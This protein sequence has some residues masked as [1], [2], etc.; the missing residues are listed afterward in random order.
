MRIPVSF[1]DHDRLFAI[2]IQLVRD[3]LHEQR[4]ED[5]CYPDLFAQVMG[6][7][8]YDE[9]LS[10]RVEDIHV[11]SQ[12][13]LT[14]TILRDEMVWNAFTNGVC[15]YLQAGKL[16]G[17]IHRER[18]DC[19]LLTSETR[20]ANAVLGTTT[21]RPG[22]TLFSNPF[23]YGS[24]GLVI[25]DEFPYYSNP[26][27]LT[28]TPELIE[29]GAPLYRSSISTTGLAFCW[30]L[31]EGTVRD[32]PDDLDERLSK[33]CHYAPLTDAKARRLRFWQEEIIPHNFEP[34][35]DYARRKFKLPEGVE[36]VRT[37]T[38]WYLHNKALGGYIPL[39]FTPDSNA[40]YQAV[41]ALLCGQT[42]EFSEEDLGPEDAQ[43]FREVLLKE[44][45]APADHSADIRQ[46]CGRYLED[47]PVKAEEVFF[48]NWQPYLR[49]QHWITPG[50]VPPGIAETCTSVNLHPNRLSPLALPT[51][52][53]GFNDAL[54]CEFSITM[55][56]A[57]E[58]L[59]A[60]IRSRDLVTLT[61]TLLTYSAVSL[62]R[63]VASEIKKEN[64]V[65]RLEGHWRKEDPRYKNA[66]AAELEGLDAMLDNYQRE[67]LKV[68]KAFPELAGL[69]V[70]TLG[71][72][73]C[74]SDY[75]PRESLSEHTNTYEFE[76]TNTQHLVHY[77]CFA[78][79]LVSESLL[80]GGVQP[81]LRNKPA[82]MFA[83]SVLSEAVS[84]QKAD[85]PLTPLESKTLAEMNVHDVY[86]STC[87][88]MKRMDEQDS[89]ISGVGTWRASQA[90]LAL[91]RQKG[92][93]LFAKDLVS[94]NRE[95]TMGE[96][97]QLSR[98]G[99]NIS[100]PIMLNL[101]TGV[102]SI[103]PQSKSLPHVHQAEIF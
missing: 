4:G 64:P 18:F 32:L 9:L 3:S 65:E 70:I 78:I 37:T 77:L 75:R 55:A 31:L 1:A 95:L 87:A 36:C 71:W 83:I 8:N 30:T 21:F 89:F 57:S 40:F 17:A 100:S 2:H 24:P 23:A 51:W 16:V 85:L 11:H 14:R 15:G 45:P 74:K 6:Y 72:L 86:E 49:S 52:C 59:E 48:E 66:M 99:S 90:E 39:A 60:S 61:A 20:A 93:Y 22:Q 82:M 5:A 43:G 44:P 41:M 88:F 27:W 92:E 7:G 26:P 101:E 50:E 97:M 81:V 84:K 46:Q 73:H 29:A 96:L 56:L 63:H 79:L 28:Q 54:R 19:D 33:V 13:E 58:R 91:I 103:A 10:A 98:G 102:A 94:L 34:A 35:V 67:G 47:L 62:E 38:H 42:I 53:I 68:T 25:Y 80:S 12:L 69:S 76:P